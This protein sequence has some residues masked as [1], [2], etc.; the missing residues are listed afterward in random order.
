MISH[1]LEKFDGL[2][3][4]SRQFNLLKVGTRLRTV[5]WFCC[6]LLFFWCAGLFRLGRFFKLA[7]RV[8]L[9]LVILTNNKKV[10]NIDISCFSFPLLSWEHKIVVAVVLRQSVLH[11]C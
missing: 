5:V 6:L 11:N 2:V 3:C 7:H 9:L 10:M 4:P 1:E 8:D